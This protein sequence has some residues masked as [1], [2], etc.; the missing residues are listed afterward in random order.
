MTT[1]PRILSLDIETS[2]NLSHVW[3]IWRQPVGYKM[4]LDQWDMMCFSAKW[5]GEGGPT[6]SYSEYHDGYRTM[7]GSVHS[8]LDAADMI[9][10]YN[11]KRF[12]IKRIRTVLVL[13]GY[14]PFSEPRHIDLDETM[15]RVFDFPSHS[16]EYVSKM[17]G[18][19][20]KHE[21]GY[22]LWRACLIDRDPE[23]WDKMVAYCANDVEMLERLYLKVLP[24]IERHPSVTPYQELEPGVLSCTKCGSIDLVKDGYAYTNVSVFQRYRC[25]SCGNR[26]LRGTRR[27]NV[28]GTGITEAGS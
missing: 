22:E 8:F 20:G 15:K 1:G 6:Y 25:R 24:W 4:L 7:L 16:M 21:T 11:G 26:A 9:L 19:P 28:G 13:A 27:V 17:F 5:V 18:F 10:T 12:D 23:S 14:G 2:P 3:D